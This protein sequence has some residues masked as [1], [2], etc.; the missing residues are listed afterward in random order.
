MIPVASGARSVEQS[1]A[2]ELYVSPFVPMD[3]V[4]KFH[5]E[6]PDD[7][8]VIR[9]DETDPEGLLLRASFS[10]ARQP[11]S[12]RSLLRV[13]LT[14]PLMTLKVTAAI[15]WEALKL[16]LKGVP[17]LVRKPAVTKVATTVVGTP[18]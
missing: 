4:Y 12:D 15:H 5:I 7:N 8:V 18:R 14:Y 11:L 3:C 13:L 1:C 6:P 16:L 2:K 10:G 9:I 17:Y